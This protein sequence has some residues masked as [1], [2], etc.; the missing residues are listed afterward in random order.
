MTNKTIRSLSNINYWMMYTKLIPFVSIIVICTACSEGSE[1]GNEHLQPVEL[2]SETTISCELIANWERAKT[3]TR[4]YLETMPAEYYD[5]RPT[6]EILPFAHEFLHLACVNYRYAAM[7]AGGNDCSSYD[8]LYND[9]ALQTKEA[10]ITFVMD[11]YDAMIARLKAEEDLSETT[12]YYRWSCSKECLALK[13]F[14]HQTHHRGK[15]A[16]YLRLKGITPPGHMLIEDWSIDKDITE[17]EW[18]ASDAYQAYQKL[19]DVE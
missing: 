12:Y 5:F 2:T 4:Q 16:I 9:P 8:D 10:V 1:T 14:E 13:G 7:I 3:F 15:A 11:S 19:V 17:E 18:I 6:P